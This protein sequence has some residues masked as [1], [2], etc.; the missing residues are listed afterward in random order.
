[1]L[2]YAGDGILYREAPQHAVDN[3]DGIPALL[4][5]TFIKSAAQK[6]IKLHNAM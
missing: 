5:I 1:M 3:Y 6:M 2:Y 4:W